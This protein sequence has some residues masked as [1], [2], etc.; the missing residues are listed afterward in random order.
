MQKRGGAATVSGA[1]PRIVTT[2]VCGK[3]KNKTVKD[4][5]SS[6]GADEDDDDDA[7]TVFAII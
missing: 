5:G 4:I 1:A 2:A 6:N 7:T 3:E